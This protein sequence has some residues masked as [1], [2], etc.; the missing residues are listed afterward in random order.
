MSRKRGF[1]GADHHDQE[2]ELPPHLRYRHAHGN[3]TSGTGA[4]FVVGQRWMSAMEPDL[5]IGEVTA[6]EGR[7][8]SI[9]FQSGGCVRQ[10]TK[11]NAPLKRVVFKVGDTIRTRESQ[12]H[13]VEEIEWENGLVRY[14]TPDG[15]LSESSLS[16]TMTFTAPFDRLLTGHVDTSARFDL[17]MRLWA[18]RFRLDKSPVRGFVG[19]RI[20]LIPHQL[21]IAREMTSR[22]VRR[23]LLAD[24]VGLGK[25]IEACLILHRLMVTG[26]LGRVL[27]A[28]PEA[29][30]NVWFVELLRKFNLLFRIFNTETMEA[31]AGK[32]GTANPFLDASLVLV[33]QTT[34]VSNK[35]AGP[36]AVRAGWDM[37]IVDEAHHL[38]ENGPAY[39]L[40]AELAKVSRDILLLTAT[41]R[42]HGDRSHFARLRLLDPSRYSNY[43]RYRRESE[44]HRKVADVAARLLDG[45][46]LT[47]EDFVALRS[48]FGGG[49]DLLG[50]HGQALAQNSESARRR[51]VA[52]LL[53]RHG[54]GRAMFRNTRAA[55]GGFPLR[56]VE[57]RPLAVAQEI[58]EEIHRSA[59]TTNPKE[60][61]SDYSFRD[62]PR[63]VYVAEL[64]R[65]VSTEK[66]LLI[67]RRKEHAIGVDEALRRLVGYPT[68][69]FHEDMS[70][71]QRDRNA[72]WFADAEGARIL[73]CSEIGGEGRNFQ[74]VHHLVLFDLPP[75]PELVE[76]RIGR[77][78]RIGQTG[79]VIIHVPYVK[80]TVGEVY[81]RL[82]HRGLDLFAGTAPAA[83]EVFEALRERI[84]ELTARPLYRDNSWHE[85]LQRLIVEAKRR[86]ETL[87]KQYA[88]GRDRL[89]ELHSF[90]PN[91]AAELIGRIREADGDTEFATVFGELLR[92][93]GVLI[94]EV[95]GRTWKLW[96]ATEIDEYFPGLR[97]SRPMVTF[98]RETALKH[99]DYEFISP[100]HPAVSGA[101]EGFL[102]SE[103][104]NAALAWWPAEG[105]RELL[106][107]AVYI[108]ECV[109][110]PGLE[111]TRFLPPEPVRLVINHRLQDRS[112]ECDAPWSPPLESVTSIPALDNPE[113]KRRV[114][115]AMEQ[116]AV[117]CAEAATKGAIEKALA[118]VRR[119]V[120]GELRRLVALR[121]NNPAIPQE[122]IDA[123][124]ERLEILEKVVAGAAPRLDAV[125]LI[126]KSIQPPL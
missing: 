109:A 90:R 73:L 60:E 31:L 2:Q 79:A 96:S 74:F 104:G 92:A 28:V 123:A 101:L 117:K 93:R 76:Q 122:E 115:P 41:P 11:E 120:G 51:L 91:E 8:V 61:A 103:T 38:E 59:V 54:I 78:D 114:L 18:L 87:N 55:V 56:R 22:C 3:P 7:R 58:A 110:P 42:H 119:S 57:I 14:K 111:V 36:W 69:L 105:E 24:E 20:D 29:L 89:L 49:E 5:G 124:G 23:A 106:L 126:L 6:V 77:L 102:G 75:D 121:K 116:R 10:Y 39:R 34:L 95:K 13:T 47:K 65:S 99:E 85:E 83:G 98:D 35:K 46:E 19:G 16:D 1:Y 12:K 33:D 21:Y 72:A 67:C 88:L 118:E 15:L 100:D 62:D 48:F 66:V 53:D 26:R 43:E 97:S 70:L 125:R 81:A 80:A 84:S 40:T 9:T 82:Y 50:S 30:V 44:R 52:E 64:L 86:T 45:I 37:L 71:I 94:E 4:S 32:N 25:T 113:L 68:A 108:I 107:E 17:R 63:I 27:I 112:S